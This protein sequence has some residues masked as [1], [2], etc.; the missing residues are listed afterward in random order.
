M[1]R[2][3]QAPPGKSIAVTFHAVVPLPFWEW[4]DAN[5]RMH[6]RFG[7]HDLGDLDQVTCEN[8]A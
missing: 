7:N 3:L 5:S 1:P 2:G 6:I 4:E 8:E